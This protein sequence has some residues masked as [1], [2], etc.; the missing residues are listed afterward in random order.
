M[1]VV[2]D[3]EML[4]WKMV[5]LVLGAWFWNVLL[6][7]LWLPI[8][9]RKLQEVGY[10]WAERLMGK[11]SISLIRAWEPIVPRCVLC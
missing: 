8:P 11:F 2:V 10:L 7:N 5:T 1:S 3:I 9:Y 6:V 4:A